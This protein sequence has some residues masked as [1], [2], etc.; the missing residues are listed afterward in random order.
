LFSASNAPS[1]WWK[2]LWKKVR[3]QFDS[4]GPLIHNAQEMERLGAQGVSTI[5]S[6]DE[7]DGD[8]IAVIRAHGVP[9][10]VQHDL[11][12]R[13]AKVIDAYLS[14][15]DSR[16]TPRRTWPHAK[17]EMSVVAGNPDHPEMIGV[18]GLCPGQYLCCSRCS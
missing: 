6:P 5:D 8:T 17:A 13:A 12:E 3:D 14:V 2:K 1:K 9:P 11:E 10:Q 4:L 16:P 15:C 18:V 7:A